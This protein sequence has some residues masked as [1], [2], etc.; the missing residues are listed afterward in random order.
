MLQAHRRARPRSARPVGPLSAAPAQYRA[1]ILG[2]VVARLSRVPIVWPNFDPASH[3]VTHKVF[4]MLFAIFPRPFLGFKSGAD[5]AR[6]FGAC[7][8]VG[9]RWSDLAR[10]YGPRLY[11][12]CVGIWGAGLR[13]RFAFARSIRERR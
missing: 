7:F 10:R 5:R 12:V 9:G 1:R 8:I 3:R 4:F 6:R 2:G 11:V 13:Y